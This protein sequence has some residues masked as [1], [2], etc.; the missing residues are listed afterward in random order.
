MFLLCWLRK[1][2]VDIFTRPSVITWQRGALLSA[3]H[4]S[5]RCY[6]TSLVCTYIGIIV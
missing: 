2:S 4:C 5:Q 3:P 6:N 1:S